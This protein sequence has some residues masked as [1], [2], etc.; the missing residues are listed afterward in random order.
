MF[1][2]AQKIAY[3]YLFNLIA[4]VILP[5]HPHVLEAAGKASH[6]AAAIVVRIV[7]THAAV[8]TAASHVVATA[9]TTGSHAAIAT[10]PHAPTITTAAHPGHECTATAATAGPI[11]LRVSHLHWGVSYHLYHIVGE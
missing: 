3:R 6:L 10:G 2:P 11:S 9:V 7:G 8:A 4:G 1:F 5:V